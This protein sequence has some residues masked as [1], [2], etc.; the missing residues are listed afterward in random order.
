[1]DGVDEINSWKSRAGTSN[2][3]SMLNLLGVFDRYRCNNLDSLVD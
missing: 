1:M 3:L 2:T